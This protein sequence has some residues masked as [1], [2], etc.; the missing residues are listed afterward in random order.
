MKEL[1]SI[2][3]QSFGFSVVLTPIF[4]DIFRSFKV[5]D[6]PDQDRKVHVYPIPRVG[7]I[8]IA[9]AYF[10]A[11]YFAQ[12]ND[13][14]TLDQELSVVWN[15]LPAAMVVFATGLI[16]D[17]FGLKPWQKILGQLAAAGMAAW[18]GVRILDIGGHLIPE[19]WG[20]LLTIGWLLVCT[21]AINL[22]DGLDGLAAG[23]SLFATLTIFAAAI[24]EGNQPLAF[25]T[26]PLA[27]CLLGFLCF[28]FNPATVFLG[29]CGSLLVGFLLGCFGVLWTQK[30]VTLLGI[31]APLM[32]LSLPLLDVML[33]IV[34]RWLRNQPIFSADRG[35]IHHRLLDRGLTP[36]QAV[37]L[38]YGLCGLAATFSLIQSLISNV[39][40]AGFVVVV[41]VAVAWMGIHYLE[42]SEFILAGRLLRI[43]AF[44]RSVSANLNLTSFEKSMAKAETIDDCWQT[45]LAVYEIFGFAAI[46][47]RVAGVTYQR[48]DPGISPPH[49]WTMR[50]P[51]SDKDYVELARPFGSNVLPMTVVPFVDILASAL[52]AKL[53]DR[54]PS[55]MNASVAL[56]Q[57]N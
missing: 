20:I 23:V 10:L 44:Q 5:V 31:T 55:A 42:Y 45:L 24:L 34:R 38:L 32:A 52:A 41:F 1:L 36:R 4:R 17:F 16:D 11:F 49:Y 18:A 21:N 28:N 51:I 8:A 40:L 2:G 19:F 43:G 26:L 3:L 37:F 6:S 57:G 48:W 22:V 29:D 35:H 46:R 9:V 14:R 25:A 53:E 15:I 30:S 54:A 39:Y 13:G 56:Q 27:G 50:L 7:G 12:P 33:C 47:M